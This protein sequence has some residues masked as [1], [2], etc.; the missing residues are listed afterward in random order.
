MFVLLGG[1]IIISGFIY[2]RNYILNILCKYIIL[3]ILGIIKVYYYFKNDKDGIKIKKSS[4]L[5]NPNLKTKNLKVEEYEITLNSKKN[6]IVLVAE[7]SRS[8]TEQ[9]NELVK[10]INEK[11][12]NKNKIVYCSIV[13]ENGDIII[14]LTNMLRSFVYYF[15]KEDF[16]LSIFFDYV[17]DYL[18]ARTDIYDGLNVYD[19]DLIIYLND[20][21]FTELGY[22]INYIKDKSIIDILIKNDL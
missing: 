13:N 10:N 11:L 18:D 4:N 21:T 22:K 6:N 20:L 9:F 14:E 19:F 1:F 2:Y 7:S 8:L 5:H 17:Q 12:Q 16:K 15:D 3:C